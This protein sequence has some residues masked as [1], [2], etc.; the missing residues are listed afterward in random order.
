MNDSEIP[1]RVFEN[2]YERRSIRKYLDKPI[3]EW[4]LR[5]I[6]EAGLRAPSA[7]GAQAP[8]LVLCKDKN[9]N[10]QLG[11]LSKQLYKE[12]FYPVSTAQPSIADDPSIEDGFYGAPV[13]IHGFTPKDYPYSPYD[14]AM[15]SCCMMLGAWSLGIGS[16]YI[17]RAK[18]L[19]ETEFGLAIKDEWGVPSN[20]EGAFHL[21]L[22]YA[23]DDSRS[24][25]P[26]Y[27]G[28]LIAIE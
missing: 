10:L 14:A 7:G 9:L 26:L 5:D 8:T 18:E 16:C 11:R 17:S 15:S 1:N 23:S 12:G 27:D 19:F 2:L 4:K 3:E 6:C 13:M 22:G 24:F 20:Y 21:C 25:K 28:R